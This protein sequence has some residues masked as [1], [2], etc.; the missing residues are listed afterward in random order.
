MKRYIRSDSA[1][2]TY[3]GYPY[4]REN[5]GRG[6]FYFLNDSGLAIYAPDKDKLFRSIDFVIDFREPGS[7]IEDDVSGEFERAR[8][9]REIEDEE[10]YYDLTHSE[11]RYAEE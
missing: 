10:D 6:R 7:A 9:R 11:G 5:S 2:G 4:F 1:V 3:R 8:L